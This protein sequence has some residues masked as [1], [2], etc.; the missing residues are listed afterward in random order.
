MIT[1]SVS[2]FCLFGVHMGDTSTWK[3]GKYSIPEHS[4]LMNFGGQH[5]SLHPTEINE[6]SLKGHRG[7]GPKP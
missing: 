4:P 2:A 7:A 1:F 6:P 5:S 3:T